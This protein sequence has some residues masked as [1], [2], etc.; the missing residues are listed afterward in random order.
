MRLFDSNLLVTILVMTNN[1]GEKK[2]AVQNIPITLY[3]MI[4]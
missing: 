2:N 3:N 4:I 1:S